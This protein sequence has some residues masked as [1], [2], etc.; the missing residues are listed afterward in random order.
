[1]SAPVGGRRVLVLDGDQAQS[2]AIVRSLGR[3]S[4]TVDVA[5]N[6]SPCLCGYSRYASETFTYPDPM[7][8]PSAFAAAIRAR[9]K[10]VAYDLVVP[11]TEDTL[12]PL[13]KERSTFEGLAPL[14]IASDA[15]LDVVM[16]KDKTFEL[17]ERLGVPIPK[18]WNVDS[19]AALEA[20]AAE[21]DYPVVL[22]P[23]RSIAAKDGDVATRMSVGYAH[24]RDDFMM[25][26][27]SAI[28]Y[29][30]L[31]VQEY[32]RGAGVGI[33]LLA[34]HGEVV[35]AFQHRRMHEVPLTGGGSSLRESV[36]IDPA[37][38]DYSQRL[39]AAIEWHGVGMVEFKL[40]ESTG[41]CRLMEINGRFWGSLPL[42]VAAG[43]DFPYF[44]FELYARG[45]RPPPEA[46][47][48]TGVV[49]RKLARDLWW[50]IEV[51][52]RTDDNPLIE[53][54]SRRQAAADLLRVL[55]PLHRF[56][57]QSLVDPV[58]GAVDLS[59]AWS[60]VFGRFSGKLEKSLVT[61]RMQRERRN[62]RLAERLRGAKNVL[63]GCYGN[64]NRSV[65][66]ERH[67]TSKLGRDGV[68]VVSAGFHP[69]EGRPPDPTM[70]TVAR[71]RGV[72][73]DGAASRRYTAEMVEAA[74]VILVMEVP[75][76]LQLKREFP[77][78]AGKTF[79]LG[80][81]DRVPGGPLEI[82]DPYGGEPDVYERCFEEVTAYT[83]GIASLLAA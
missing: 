35:H 43:S 38:L 6:V 54:P 67:L 21:L 32:F 31:I 39:V 29:G 42:A 57:V 23:S 37:L 3:Q 75:H 27:S 50:Y 5:A 49:C 52:R 19:P 80:C 70:A 12:V 60:D 62:A 28:A 55:H 78:S 36:P 61:K 2:L 20:L 63:F 65:L 34:D 69:K 71:L 22:K 64:I 81:V 41:E 73:L 25:K 10:A 53:W 24:A 11:V 33:E 58:P 17:A 26:A 66:A 51:L 7:A 40:D 46:R 1:M 13:A 14:A 15:A 59:R 47:A 18:S 82:S 56:V 30:P 72:S 8:D 4:V 74:D 9:T 83:E 68:T 16:N 45:E 77:A 44:L 79:L 48:R 76:V